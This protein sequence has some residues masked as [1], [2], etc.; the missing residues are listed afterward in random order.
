MPLQKLVGGGG[1]GP[2]PGPFAG[3]GKGQA[4][5]QM[6]EMM[7][8]QTLDLVVAVAALAEPDHLVDE[9]D[10]VLSLSHIQLDKYSKQSTYITKDDCIFCR[11]R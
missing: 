10:L 6:L 1:N 8:W 4:L 7:H 11:I 3:A 5:L 2:L 9:V